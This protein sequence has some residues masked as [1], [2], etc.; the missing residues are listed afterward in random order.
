MEY[1][2]IITQVEIEFSFFNEY[3]RLPAE[4][5]VYIPQA[6]SSGHSDGIGG[7]GAVVTGDAG[8]LIGAC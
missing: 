2:L 8:R 3:R 1:I 6:T 5:A 4:M 7:S